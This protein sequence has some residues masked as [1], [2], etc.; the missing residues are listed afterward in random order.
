[1]PTPSPAGPGSSPGGRSDRLRW[2][3][4]PSPVALVLA[5]SAAAVLGRNA[6][7]GGSFARTAGVAVGLALLADLLGALLPLRRPDLVVRPPD[8]AT[9]GVPTSLDVA[10]ARPGRRIELRIASWD[11]GGWVVVDAPQRLR[12]PA[13]PT[14]RGV[15]DEVRVVLRATGPFGLV[16]AERTL[17]IALTHALEVAPAAL[18]ADPRWRVAGGPVS[19]TASH[20][21]AV[22]EYRPGDP[23]RM[24]NWPATARTGQLMVT[25]V[26]GEHAGDAVL[27]VDLGPNPGDAAERAAGEALTVGD[28]LL[29][30][31]VRLTVL[32]REPDGP[33][34]EVVADGR[35]LGRCL[36][37]AVPGPPLADADADVV[38][39][40]TGRPSAA[41]DPP[42]R[43]SAEGAP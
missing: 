38:V 7:A 14:A 4:R 25:E 26:D 36:A 16:D 41:S 40:P 29:R 8:A 43:P 6:V 12:V 5:L 21:R 10:V 13:T 33:R 31:G 18:P 42:G 35:Q 19:I 28:D 32:S 22:R 15:V 2:R 17:A 23:R 39:D 11:G 3:V 20:P 1:V 27:L 24:V 34:R 37:R 30:R 9:A